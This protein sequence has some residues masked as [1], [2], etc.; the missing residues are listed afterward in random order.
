METIVESTINPGGY[1]GT[2]GYRGLIIRRVLWAGG[3]DFAG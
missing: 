2:Y 1:H 3:S